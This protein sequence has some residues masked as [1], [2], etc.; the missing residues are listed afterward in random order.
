MA[1]AAIIELFI[2]R[3]KTNQLKDA[4]DNAKTEIIPF[5]NSGALF[6]RATLENLAVI[7]IPIITDNMRVALG[8][9]AE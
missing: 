1:L 8:A 9:L 7:Q 6:S 4:I 3:V 2:V 5:I